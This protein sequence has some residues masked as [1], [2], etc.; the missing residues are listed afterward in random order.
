MAAYLIKRLLLI[1]PTM[2]GI[3]TISFIIIQFAPGGPVERVIA[4]ISGTDVSATARIGGGSSDGL[5]TQNR[6]QAGPSAEGGAPR[7]LRGDRDVLRLRRRR[8]HGGP[9]VVDA[10]ARV[11]G[12]VRDRRRP[13][14]RGLLVQLWPW[15]SGGHS[16]FRVESEHR[17]TEGGHEVYCPARSSC[18]RHGRRGVGSRLFL[19]AVPGRVHVRFVR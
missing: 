2:L 6:P 17:S 1:I 8:G 10:A 14:H 4:Q 18:L 3:M 9:M 13:R 7:D 11:A 5:S 12:N 19:N 16:D 15:S